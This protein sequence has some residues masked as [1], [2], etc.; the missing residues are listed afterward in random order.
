MVYLAEKNPRFFYTDERLQLKFDYSSQLENFSSWWELNSSRFND[1]SFRINNQR[2]LFIDTLQ[3]KG[4]DEAFAT[5]R[6]DVYGYYLE[7]IKQ[8]S[9]LPFSLRFDNRGRLIGDLYIDKPMSDMVDKEER[10]GAVYQGILD[11]ELKLKQLKE[12]EFIFRTSPQGWTGKN[13]QYTETQSQIY[14]RDGGKIRGLT[15]RTDTSLDAILNFLKS[16]DIEINSNLPEKEKLKVI[17]GLNIQF[18]DF[19]SFLRLFLNYFQKTNRNEAINENRIS[20][21]IGNHDLF[22]FYDEISDIVDW[23]RDYLMNLLKNSQQQELERGIDFLFG[24]ILMKLT[25]KEQ[26]KT[27]INFDPRK[28]QEFNFYPD[29]RYLLV[30]Q[31]NYESLFNSLKMMSG[32]SGGGNNKSEKLFGVNSWRGSFENNIFGPRGILFEEKSDK[33]G[34]LEFECPHCHKKVERPENTL[35]EKCPKCG[36]DVKCG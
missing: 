7:Y 10:E 14:W 5:L 9:Y 2:D 13:Y 11:L 17:T 25:E 35:I 1:F 18:S 19:E 6:L 8:E 36:G 33:Y 29:T 28:Q 34:S 21:M 23:S 27:M 15:I 26:E 16:L 4:F 12:G 3:K 30:Y 20:Q 24:F 22:R 31:P 32:C